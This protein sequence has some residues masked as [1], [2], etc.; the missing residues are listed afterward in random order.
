L[1]DK[2]NIKAVVLVISA[3]NLAVRKPAW[4]LN[5]FLH[6]AIWCDVF[7]AWPL[8]AVLKYNL[9]TNLSRSWTGLFYTPSVCI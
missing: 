4:L 8:S 3:M 9:G 2:C 7:A 1:K 5:A 6:C